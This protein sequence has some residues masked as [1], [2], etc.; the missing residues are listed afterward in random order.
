MI[1]PSKMN[2]QYNGDTVLHIIVK[3][4]EIRKT[5]IGQTIIGLLVNH[6]CRLDI[7]DSAGKTPVEYT[8]KG[9]QIF[10]L[11]QNASNGSTGKEIFALIFF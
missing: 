3:D 11:L 7:K 8:S 5:T 2:A 1:E 9:D 4:L 6:G 10:R